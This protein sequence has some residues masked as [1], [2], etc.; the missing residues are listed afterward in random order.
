MKFRVF[1][2]M[3]ATLV[4]AGC[5]SL[6]D[7]PAAPS[8][9]AAWSDSTTQPASLVAHLPEDTLLYARIPSLMAFIGAPKP[10]AMG[11]LLNSDANEAALKQIF[12]GT[13]NELSAL[14]QEGKLVNLFLERLRSPLEVAVRL[15]K[16]AG[17]TASEIYASARLDFDSREDFQQQLTE[18]TKFGPGVRLHSLATED[19]AG[20]M[21]LGMLPAYYQFNA[22]NQRFTMVAGFSVSSDLLAKIDT[23]TAPA[24]PEHPALTHQADMEDSGY[25]LYVWANAQAALPQITPFIPQHQL[26]ELRDSGL[27][28]VEEIAFAIGTAQGKGQ[29]S[30]Y[31][32]GTEGAFWEMALPP[33]EAS[34]LTTLGQPEVLFTLAL[35]GAEWMDQILA[36]LDE[37]TA[38]LDA[39]LRPYGMSVGSILE[40]INGRISGV[41]DAA[42]RYSALEPK[43]P[44]AFAKLIDQLAKTKWL[45]VTASEYQGKTIEHWHI[46]TAD[47]MPMEQMPG[48]D[49]I[50][51]SQNTHIW[52]LRTDDMWLLAPI[53]QVLMARIDLDPDFKVSS[54]LADQHEPDTERSLVLM[55]SFE[56]RVQTNYHFYLEFLQALGETM[57]SPVD[58]MTFPPAYAQ[59]IP[60]TSTASLSMT[61]QNNAVRLALGYENHPLDSF[62]GSMAAL[63]TLGI[64]SA[65]AIP[66]YQEYLEQVEATQF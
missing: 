27:L 40:G 12:A 26:A 7:K 17:M 36:L 3:A 45:T 18:L 11:T 35:P 30:A 55:G 2:A 57:N 1:L 34:R 56:H 47:F 8:R 65:V 44:A 46:P 16:G 53:P 59:A 52:A 64:I 13:R 10:N 43:D 54:W 62:G 31:A 49:M 58:L 61:Y 6:S 25:G 9:S 38:T 33:A 63:A 23:G 41:R 5:S 15:P 24:N 14:G 4:A 39:E 20:F 21:S 50:S 37:D 32:S 29:I 66:Q 48:G 42:G 22:E 28:S 19:T 60:D 51:R